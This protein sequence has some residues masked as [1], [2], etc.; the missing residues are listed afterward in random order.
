MHVDESC[1]CVRLLHWLFYAT[2]A[3]A[4]SGT[5]PATPSPQ[6]VADEFVGRRRLQQQYAQQQPQQGPA[7]M[8]VVAMSNAQNAKTNANAN[9][10]A[11]RSNSL[12]ESAASPIR[13]QNTA[14]VRNYVASSANFASTYTSASIQAK[15]ATTPSRYAPV[16]SP[17]QTPSTSNRRQQS[18]R[19]DTRNSS[20]RSAN[21]TT[22][23]PHSAASPSPDAHLKNLGSVNS[24]E[25]GSLEFLSPTTPRP[26]STSSSSSPPQPPVSPS[27]PPPSSS[28][29]EAVEGQAASASA[30]SVDE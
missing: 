9:A 26:S 1:I 8:D 24:S 5:R 29:S 19:V 28:A 11:A 2:N 14:A 22:A 4:G 25:L 16:E 7:G 10:N 17:S 20:T 21:G 13:S 3:A 18:L 30:T 15:A 12:R 6:D 23:T 27:L